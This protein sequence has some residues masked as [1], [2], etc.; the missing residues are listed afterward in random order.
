MKDHY[1][2]LRLEG[3]EPERFRT[4]Q[5]AMAKAVLAL[6]VPGGIWQVIDEGDEPVLV[7][8][9]YE[10]GGLDAVEAPD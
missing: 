7:V 3:M 6:G 10:G 5:G 1:Y 2:E 4:L 8:V 9:Y